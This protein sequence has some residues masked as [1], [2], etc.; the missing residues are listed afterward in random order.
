M[1]VKFGQKSKPAMSH[2]PQSNGITDRVHAV[3]N[4]ILRTHCFSETEIDVEDPLTD[5]LSS[6]AFAIQVSCHSTPE[7]TPGQLVFNRDMV[8]PVKFNADWAYISETV[9]TD[10]ERQSTRECK[11][12][13]SSIPRRIQGLV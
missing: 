12:Y 9:K 4:D 7:A 10:T 1:I 3:L 13:S 8:L 6:T 5:I 2:N 11:T